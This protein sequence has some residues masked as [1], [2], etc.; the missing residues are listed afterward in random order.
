MNNEIMKIAKI[1][2]E[3]A[4]DDDYVE[5]ERYLCLIYTYIITHTDYCIYT[6][7]QANKSFNLSE[8]IYINL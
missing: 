8:R 3:Q 1:R 5:G 2:T 6:A 7:E 4:Y